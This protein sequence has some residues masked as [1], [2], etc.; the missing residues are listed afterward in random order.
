[1]WELKIKRA[2]LFSFEL[3]KQDFNS[4]KSFII[5]LTNYAPT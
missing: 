3:N 1:M 2:I 4:L 5:F